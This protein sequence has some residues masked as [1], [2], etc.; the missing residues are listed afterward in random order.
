MFTAIYFFETDSLLYMA[1]ESGGP[2]AG[3]RL[4]GK[5][6]VEGGGGPSQSGG[7]ALWCGPDRSGLWVRLQVC[8]EAQRPTRSPRDSVFS[9]AHPFPGSVAAR[10]AKFPLSELK[11]LIQSFSIFPFLTTG[12]VCRRQD[13]KGNGSFF[14]FDNRFI[15]VEH[16]LFSLQWCSARITG[17]AC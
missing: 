14:F 5:F 2:V 17:I 7:V 11:F 15:W 12:C 4:S 6:A 1:P 16:V 8:K 10:H 3:G 13:K 9:S